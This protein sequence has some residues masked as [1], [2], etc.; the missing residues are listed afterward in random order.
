MRRR[1]WVTELLQDVRYAFRLF[2]RAPAFTAVAVTTLAL[3]IG[4]ANTAV[5]S[6]IDSVLLRP[7]PFKDP[8]QLCSRCR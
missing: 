1:R 3:G 2:A 8:E 5:F 4:G 6:A 7:L